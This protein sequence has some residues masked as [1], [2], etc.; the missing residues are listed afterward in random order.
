MPL[1]QPWRTVAPGSAQLI[2]TAQIPADYPP[3]RG[4]GA[5]VAWQLHLIGCD[6]PGYRPAKYR[7]R[8]TPDRQQRRNPADVLDPPLRIRCDLCPAEADRTVGGRLI[9]P[10]M[11]GLRANSWAV[12]PSA[13]R[14]HRWHIRLAGS[15]DLPR[16][17]CNSRMPL[18]AESITRAADVFDDV[19][20][21]SGRCRALWMSVRSRRY[22]DS[23]PG[24]VDGQP[25]TSL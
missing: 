22:A 18:V 9:E 17:S 14:P 23:L 12:H 8:D 1:N 2:P 11:A 10:L 25:L 20:C 3:R 5:G 21:R 16:A 6:H 7:V 13:D 15:G 19:R 24:R 4:S